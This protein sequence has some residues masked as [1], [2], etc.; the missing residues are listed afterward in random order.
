MEN[1]FNAEKERKR[2]I[3]AIPAPCDRPCEIPFSEKP[4]S[5][6][7][8]PRITREEP[9][10]EGVSEAR[11]TPLRERTA[12]GKERERG[13]RKEMDSPSVTKI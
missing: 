11:T 4:D 12:R 13:R 5:A 8:F 3:F 6:K 2:K 1:V 9:R 10:E 7:E